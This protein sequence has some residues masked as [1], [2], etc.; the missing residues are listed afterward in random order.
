MPLT[1]AEK[2]QLDPYPVVVFT[3][4]GF[5][6]WRSSAWTGSADFSAVAG[7]RWREFIHP[8]DLPAI[9]AALATGRPAALSFRAMAPRT[10]QP[11]TVNWRLLTHRDHVLAVGE[12][13]PL[14]QLPAPP[15]IMPTQ[16]PLPPLRR[17]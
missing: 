6:R 17:D 2:R 1:P 10:G 7:D 12:A 8:D 16:L 11:I 9:L 13:F 3:R 5:L 14:D 15:C 4:A